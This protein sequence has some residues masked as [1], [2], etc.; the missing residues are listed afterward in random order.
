MET[1]GRRSLK[2]IPEGT[3][4]PFGRC[5]FVKGKKGGIDLEREVGK[6]VYLDRVPLEGGDQRRLP[7]TWIPTQRFRQ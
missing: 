6:E 3:W 2:R 5:T 4:G 1:A 7:G